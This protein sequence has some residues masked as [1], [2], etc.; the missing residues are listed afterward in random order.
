MFD[1]DPTRL[2]K[3]ARV[4]DAGYEAV[5]VK[6]LTIHARRLKVDY[7]MLRE[8]VR[9]EQLPSWIVWRELDRRLKQLPKAS[10]SDSNDTTIA[11][12]GLYVD[13]IEV[14]KRIAE[15]VRQASGQEMLGLLQSRLVGYS[16][17][18]DLAKLLSQAS[19]L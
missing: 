3:D 7:K 8:K 5:F 12:F 11:P 1:V 14:D 10:A 18:K 4:E 2:P 17:Y 15:L 9:Q 19:A 6:M 13:Y 16:S